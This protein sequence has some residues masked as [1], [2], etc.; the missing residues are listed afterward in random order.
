DYVSAGVAFDK[1]AVHLP[2]GTL[3]AEVPSP[4]LAA[5][6]PANLGIGRPALHK[7]LGERTIAE[8][9][10]VRLGVTASALVDDGSGVEV[11]FSDGSSGRCAIVVGSDGV[12]SDTRRQILPDVPAPEFT[13]QAV[14]RYN[15]PRPADL[16]A[17]HVYN[18]PTGIGL[19]PISR[20]LM[21]M[22]V[23]TPEPGNPFYPKAGLAA[24]L[25]TKLADA[26]PQIRP[27]AE[28]VTDDDGAGYRPLETIMLDGPWHR[29]RVVLLGD[30]VHA[31]TPHL[32]QGAGMAVED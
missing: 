24:A 15:F 30:A 16:D 32:G 19:V 18:G 9:A 23:T 22:Y 13:G 17:L 20:E 31:T 5:G 14:W 1:V 11:T 27:L 3:V 28:Q 25:R 10:E 8:G 2:D 12:Y 6:Y 4:K 26:A 21:Y 29:G 7:V